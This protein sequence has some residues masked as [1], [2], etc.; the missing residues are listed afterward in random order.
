MGFDQFDFN[1]GICS[2]IC[3]LGYTTP[4]PIQ[5]KT[6]PLILKGS[7][8]LGLAQTGTGK[9]AAFA[10]PILERLSGSAAKAP[11]ALIMAPTRE[12]AEQIHDNITRLAAHTALKSVAVYGGV[13]KFNQITAFKR[14]VDIIVAC[15]GR[16]LDLMNDGAV[17]LRD[18]EV[19]VLDEADQMLDM[20]FLPDIRRIIS[21]LPETRQTLVFSATMPGQIRELTRRIQNRPQSVRINND[22]PAPAITHS[23]F[24]LQKQERTALLKQMLGTRD[25]GTAIV[26]TRTKH[27]AK[28]L[29]GQLSRAGYSAA[30]LQ[31]N[32][33]QQQR[34]RAMAGF[35]E[36]VFT[37]L[38]ATDIAARG[39]D[40]SG[41]SHVINYDL[42]DTVEAYIHR[43]G[44]T[45][46]ADQAGQAYTFACEDD[47]K[48]IA[49]IEKRLG[50][51]MTRESVAP[52]P[53]PTGKPRPKQKAVQPK[54]APGS[55]AKSKKSG[56][57]W[58]ESMAM[59]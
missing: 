16:L 17:S 55:R 8:V 10:L 34:K 47:G 36:G 31:G 11:R 38:V 54:K 15:P 23:L 41:I 1:P 30:A 20:G 33:S 2:G 57:A 59:A 43:T 24:S 26:F 21:Q 29:A 46:R 49:A 35:R 22:R 53:R 14:G 44:R 52:E 5:E 32:M 51:K 39:I 4:T 40:V 58:S 13:G 45:G 7:D 6:I 37:V 25:I 42:P 56:F 19:L 27:K 9:T 50:K 48:M 12:L 18:I 3:D 28:S